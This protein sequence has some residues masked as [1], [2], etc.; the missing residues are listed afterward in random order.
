MTIDRVQRRESPE[1]AELLLDLRIVRRATNPQP[2]KLPLTITVNGTATS[3]TVDL[4][5]SQLVIEGYSIPVD[6]ALKKGWGCISLPADS[7]P[8]NDKFY[9]VFD[10]APTLKSVVVTDDDTVAAPISA[11]LSAAAD[12]TATTNAASCAPATPRKFRGMR[13]RSSSGSRRCR[14]QLT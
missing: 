9:F 2:I 7:F 5:E 3:A 4:R 6:R 1:K 12:P 13:Q 11:A 10:E 14:S 8:S